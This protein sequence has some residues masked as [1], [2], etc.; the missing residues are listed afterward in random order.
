MSCFCPLILRMSHFYQNAASRMYRIDPH[1]FPTTCP[2]YSF[3]PHFPSDL[4]NVEC[5]P[6][7]SAKS[8]DVEFWSTCH[9]WSMPTQT[10]PDNIESPALLPIHTSFCAKLA[11]T[12]WGVLYQK[13][14][15]RAKINNY[16]PQI[17]WEVITCPCPWYLLLTQCQF[18]E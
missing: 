7:F 6:C 17:L 16:I 13:Q 15:S 11:Y 3:D 5:R 4:T 9:L 12:I 2:M 1:I 14:V 10:P 8:Y 18:T